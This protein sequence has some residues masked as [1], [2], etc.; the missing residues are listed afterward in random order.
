M[1]W[2]QPHTFSEITRAGLALKLGPEAERVGWY[3]GQQRRQATMDERNAIAQRGW[4]SF[5]DGVNEA[6]PMP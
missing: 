5:V 2:H 4:D 6:L 3:V 1:H